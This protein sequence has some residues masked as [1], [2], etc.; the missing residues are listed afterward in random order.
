M[1][2]EKEQQKNEGKMIQKEIGYLNSIQDNI[3]SLEI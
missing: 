2:K 3:M 1:R